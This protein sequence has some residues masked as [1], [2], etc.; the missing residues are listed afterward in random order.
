[1]C[2]STVRHLPSL[3]LL[4]ACSLT[5]AA[6]ASADERTWTVITITGAV[7]IAGAYESGSIT[8]DARNGTRLA[9]PFSLRTGSDSHLVIARGEDV[10]TIG[11]GTRLD[12]Q[13]PAHNGQD[14]VTRIHQVIGSI[15][16]QVEHRQAGAFEVHTP[17]L[18][19]VASGVTFNILVS[20]VNTTV[21][22]NEG[23]LH[24]YTPDSRYEVFLEAG[25][26]AVKTA[27]GDGIHIEEQRSL[28]GLAT[29]TAIRR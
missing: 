25:Q 10:V 16:Y 4:L 15:L 2:P 29:G 11:S 17:Y 1:M 6:V 13:A 20:A 21:A 12:V 5:S 3:L 18:V 19:S 9:A 8:L 28:S 24:V 26:V 22:L 27:N 7:A 14:P 23:L